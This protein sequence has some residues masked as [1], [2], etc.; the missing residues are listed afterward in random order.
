MISRGPSAKTTPYAAIIV[1]LCGIVFRRI[2]HARHLMHECQKKP[3]LDGW[4]SNWNTTDGMFCRIPLMDCPIVVD[5]AALSFFIQ[6]HS[7]DFVG[8][9]VG[10]K[11]ISEATAAASFCCCE[12]FLSPISLLALGHPYG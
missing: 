1:F 6:T 3:P 10:K 2:M 11:G 9:H 8:D 12:E 5:S 7:L 4:L